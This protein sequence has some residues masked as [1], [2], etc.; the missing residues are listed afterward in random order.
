VNKIYSMT[1]VLKSEQY[2]DSV[3][4]E[5]IKELQTEVD[6]G[7]SVDLSAWLGRYASPWIPVSTRHIKQGL[8]HMLSIRFSADVI[9][10]LFYGGNFS[11]I[12]NRAPP[13][14]TDPFRIWLAWVSGFI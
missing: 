7:N 9:G 2:V 13:A 11:T 14:R 12:K 5:L 10:E 8:I 6:D 1:N 3:V 4:E